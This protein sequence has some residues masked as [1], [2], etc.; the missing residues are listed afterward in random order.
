MLSDDSK[1]VIDSLSK[2]E[3]RLDVNKGR[4]SRF[5][6]DIFAYAKSRL[7]QIEDG[8]ASAQRDADQDLASEANKISRE[9]NS[10][11]ESANKTSSM[12]LRVSIIAVVVALVA[13]LVSMYSP[14]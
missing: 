13:I 12:A 3:L 14:K 4:R 2:E 5:Q 11:A 6:G 7:Q 9:A 1:K 8:E 10:I